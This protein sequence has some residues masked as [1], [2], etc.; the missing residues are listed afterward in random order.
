MKKQQLTNLDETKILDAVQKDLDAYNKGEKSF[1][2]MNYLKDELVITGYDEQDH[3]IKCSTKVFAKTVNA[4][5][6]MRQT[7]LS[8]LVI[9][10][11]DTTSTVIK[12]RVDMN[13]VSNG[14]RRVLNQTYGLAIPE[15]TA[16][17]QEVDDFNM[18]NF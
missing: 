10:I 16:E 11:F 13:N 5:S 2:L 6:Y 9:K 8:D 7:L 15:I 1:E 18:I 12:F 4:L 17:Y 14:Y 3:Y